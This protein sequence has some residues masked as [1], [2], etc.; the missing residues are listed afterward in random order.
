MAVNGRAHAGRVLVVRPAGQT[1]GQKEAKLM[2]GDERQECGTGAGVGA[3]TGAGVGAGVADWRPEGTFRSG[4][5][6]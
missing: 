6:A 2:Q 4:T 3:G 5:N 1:P